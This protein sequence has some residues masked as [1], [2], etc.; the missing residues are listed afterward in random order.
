MK[1]YFGSNVF[2]LETYEQ[3]SMYR[4]ELAADHLLAWPKFA[5][6]AASVQ[7]ALSETLHCHSHIL[8]SFSFSSSGI[9][10][11]PPHFSVFP[12]ALFLPRWA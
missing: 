6:K 12:P 5:L 3:V 2:P 10:C 8:P 9:G 1:F 4:W 11:F 7:A